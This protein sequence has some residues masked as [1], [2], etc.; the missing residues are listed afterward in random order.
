V[1]GELR[2]ERAGEQSCIG[3][4]GNRGNGDMEAGKWEAREQRG[5]AKRGNGSPERG[6]RRIAITDANGRAGR[7]DSDF[8]GV[9]RCARR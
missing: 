2:L 4:T 9:L 7:L 1:S 5:G 6:I 3:G 8:F